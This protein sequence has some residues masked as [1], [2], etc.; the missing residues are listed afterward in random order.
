MTT[1][2]TEKEIEVDGERLSNLYKVT[3]S[4]WQSHKTNTLSYCVDEGD[5]L[6]FED[7]VL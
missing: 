1:P 5:H 6:A 2:F 7:L 4:T 3:A